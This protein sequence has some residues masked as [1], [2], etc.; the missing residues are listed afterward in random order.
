MPQAQSPA[1]AP[2]AVMPGQPPAPPAAMPNPPAQRETQ[3]D[4]QRGREPE[5]RVRVPE[6]RGQPGRNQ[7]Q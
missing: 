3:R 1:P 5:A 2:R 6:Q 7:M 4:T